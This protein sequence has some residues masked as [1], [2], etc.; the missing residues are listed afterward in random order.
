MRNYVRDCLEIVLAACLLVLTVI[1]SCSSAF[2]C[3]HVDSKR[4]FHLHILL[5]F[6]KIEAP[7]L[8]FYP[9]LGIF[10]PWGTKNEIE[11][12]GLCTVN[13]GILSVLGIACLAILP[14]CR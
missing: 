3:L 1:S 10:C 7:G 4:S 8:V 14:L 11:A 2:W 13:Y 5:N 12:R 6:G 9:F